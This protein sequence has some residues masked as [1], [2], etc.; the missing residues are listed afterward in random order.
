MAKGKQ[1]SKERKRKRAKAR[2]IKTKPTKKR[3]LSKKRQSKRNYK[4]EYARRKELA[5]KR[6]KARKQKARVRTPKKKVKRVQRKRGPQI[7]KLSSDQLRAI[8]RWHIK[9]NP[10]GF[11]DVPTLE[12]L[13]DFA[14]ERGYAA[15]ER[16]RDTW[17]AVRA[18][19][20]AAIKSKSL[21]K[22]GTLGRDIQKLTTQARVR[23]QGDEQ[24]LYY[25]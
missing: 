2:S 10:M 1:K 4:K 6:K 14:R 22:Y 17:N 24:W 9:F 7:H 12:D 18:D 20:L 11:K 5:A 21:T 16:Y 23:P 13:I 3:V 8:R 25:H 15:F 19:Y